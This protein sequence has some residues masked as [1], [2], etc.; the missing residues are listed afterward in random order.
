MEHTNRT[1]IVDL[2]QRRGTPLPPPTALRKVG[3][4]PAQVSGR[5]FVPIDSVERVS[6]FGRRDRLFFRSISALLIP[7]IFLYPMARVY[8]DEVP[9]TS[10][11]SSSTPTVTPAALPPTPPSPPADAGDTAPTLSAT[12]TTNEGQVSTD[13]SAQPTTA[14]GSTTEQTPDQTVGGSTGGGASVGSGSNGADATSTDTTTF[15]DASSTASTTASSTEGSVDASGTEIASSTDAS[16]TPTLIENATTSNPE[17]SQDDGEPQPTQA[18]IEEAARQVAL[19]EKRM[20]D[21]LKKEVENEF[22]KGCVT[23][24]NVGYYCLKNEARDLSTTSPDKQVS[25]ESKDGGNGYKQIYVLRDDSHIQLTK[26]DWDNVFPAQDISGTEFVWQGM[27]SGRWQIFTGAI[28][29]TGSVSI[30]Q[31]TDSHDGNFNPKIDG[32]HIVW[33]GWADNNWEIFLATKRDAASPFAG[34]HLPEGNL[35]M[36][37][38]PEWEVDRLTTNID[39]DM[40]PSIHGDIVTWQAH[41]GNTWVV[42]AYS[43][44]AK[45]I[46]KLSS[47][48]VKSENPRFAITW[49]ERDASGNAHMVGYDI[50]T[51]QKEDLTSKALQLPNNPI[52]YQPRTPI[53]EPNQ[54]A[55]PGTTNT[56][57]SSPIRG[58]GEGGG[59]DLTP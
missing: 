20:R 34:E 21:E 4:Y 54:A 44:T 53:S 26:S 7:L 18:E 52:P 23:L 58:D 27:K 19:K 43:I 32:D 36:N 24:E 51:G 59:N 10:D 15:N 56:G 46:T 6:L 38:G 12:A 22:L 37:V 14:D 35:L 45:K 11:S 40:F 2:K 57:T 30:N 1:T 47:D 55:L 28:S 3:A 42:Y 49:E 25:V 41:E 48:S 17:V 16:S 50:S 31:V 5:V 9:P 33:Q 13:T 8:A 39:H 29:A